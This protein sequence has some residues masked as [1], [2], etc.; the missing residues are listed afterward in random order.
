MIPL[1][2]EWTEEERIDYSKDVAQMLFENYGVAGQY[3][4]HAPNKRSKI[5]MFTSYLLQEKFLTMSSIRKQEYLMRVRRMERL[6]ILE[7]V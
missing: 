6:Q 7:I 3:S 2:E 1:P 5:S 4:L